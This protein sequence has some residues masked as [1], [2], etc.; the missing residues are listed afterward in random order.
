MRLTVLLGC[1]ITVCRLNY[2]ALAL[3][4]TWRADGRNTECSTIEAD[5]AP[6]EV[7]LATYLDTCQKDADAI[8]IKKW[9]GRT[10]NHLHQLKNAF[11]F[12]LSAGRKSVKFRTQFNNK[13]AYL[14][15]TNAIFHFNQTL[16]VR[17]SQPSPPHG[18]EMWREGKQYEC[19]HVFFEFCSTSVAM[20]RQLY[21]TQIKPYVRSDVWTA[22]EMGTSDT[23]TIAMRDG[24]VADAR[25]GC[26]A[27]DHRP[28]NQRYSCSEHA[29]PPCRYFEMVIEH[30]NNGG[31]FAHIDLVHGG[32]GGRKQNRCVDHIK[33]KYKDKIMNH[34]GSD[35]S[36][37]EALKVDACKI[38]KA[39]NLALTMSSFAS[40]LAN[41]NNQISRYFYVDIPDE[42]LKKS[43]GGVSPR[44]IRDMNLNFTEVCQVW[45]NAQRYS[46]DSSNDLD[47]ATYFLDFPADR[48]HVDHC[49]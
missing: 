20:R 38:L 34:Q 27:R 16:P 9:M 28:R 41:M 10:G 19:T 6:S 12:A 4:Q 13:E 31:P 18:C 3:T 46:I 37:S 49:A 26:I 29:Q 23:V 42:S 32:N 24:N 48:I 8:W 25:S 33:S 30:G 44:R 47:T 39:K 35:L 1:V 2:L 17:E 40:T 21:N 43:L 11:G 36:G 7:N 45:P 14:R 22:C 5:S 15:S